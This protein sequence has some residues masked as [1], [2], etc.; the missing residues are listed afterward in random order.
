MRHLVPLVVVVPLAVAVL[1]AAASRW[2]PRLWPDLAAIVASAAVT[3][4]CLTLLLDS[5]SQRIVYWFG[6]W[7]PVDDRAVGITFVVEPVSASI[8]ALAALLVTASLVFSWRYFEEVGHLYHSLILCFLAGM[9]GF[10]LSADLFN[11]FV[12]FELMSIAAYALCG[13]QVHQASV[14][15]GAVNFAIINSLGAFTMLL[16]IALVYGSTGSLNLAQIG[17]DLTGHHPSPAV[18]AGFALLTVGFLVKAGAV[19]FHFWLSDAYAV[20]AAPVGALFAGVMSDLAY[21]TFAR[22]YW[23]AFAPAFGADGQR[24]VRALLLT[25]AVVTALVGAVMCLL[26]ADL[27]RQV[28]FLTVSHGGVFLAGI[29]LLTPRG[30]AGATLYVI[31]DGLLKTAL[32]LTFSIVVKRLGASD[33]LFLHGKGRD[34]THVLPAVVFFGCGLGLAALPPFGTFL[35][36]AL[37]FD[38]GGFGWLHVLL[39][40]SVAVSSATVLRAGARIFLGWG[41]TQDPILTSEPD[42]PTEGEPDRDEIGRGARLLLLVP[43]LVLTVVAFGIGFAPHVGGQFVMSAH[44][45]LSSHETGAVVLAGAHPPAPQPEPYSPTATAWAYG[46]AAA[47]AAVLLALL[48]LWWQRLVP[49]REALVAAVRPLKAVHDGVVGDYAVW[50]TAGAALITVVWS[51]SLR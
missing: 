44:H 41:A 51:F 31:T 24:A 45:A 22:V 4:M 36:A 16:G 8:A 19:P 48:S 12:W 7:H 20:A 28:A 10:A 3:A 27:K 15:Q 50:F 30:L 14:I 29:A 21:H 5:R 18:V 37:I 47:G 39:V 23:D 35:S 26:Q 33:E 13:Y 11:I 2:L 40:V 42:E 38:S 49:R 32:F 6:G 43:A 17:H 25:I 1:L 34:A 46:G 9:V